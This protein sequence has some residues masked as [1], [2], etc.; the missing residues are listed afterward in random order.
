VDKDDHMIEDL[1]RGLI[2]EPRFV[3]M[4]EQTSIITMPS[5]DP[6]S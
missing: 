5:L 6:Y 2:I 3:P 1:G 4:A